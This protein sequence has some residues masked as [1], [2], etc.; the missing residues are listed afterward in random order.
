MKKLRCVFMGT[1]DF[2]VPC[3]AALQAA[4]DVAAV[5]T[6][7][8]RPKGRGRKLSAPPVKEFAVNAGIEVFQPEKIKT[9]E[10]EA[11]IQALKPDV[12]VVV[13]FG[14]ILSGAILETPPLGCINVHASLLPAY[15]GA[16]PI[17]WS[18][19]RGET[20]TGVTTM[21]MDR[22]LDT[23][24]MILRREIDIAKEITTGQLHDALMHMGAEVL[25]DTL[26][27]LAEGKA[28]RQAQ[29]DRLSSYAPL[30]TK[31]IE[32]IDWSKDAKSVH[33]LIRGLNPWPGAHCRRGEKIIKVW[34]GRQAG[35]GGVLRRSPGEVVS[36]TEEGFCVETGDGIVEL[37]EVQ[38]ASKRR[39]SAREYA[40]G[41]GIQLGDRLE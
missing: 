27:L 26:R 25:M 5:V 14:Q 30:L 2:A 41:Y 17:H 24:D 22:G 4:H 38:P 23:G 32:R 20:K 37:L 29:D 36:L 13:A 35:S 34:R 15:R 16:A 19:I 10:F 7:P 11:R 40:A 9:P 8:D 3:L 1:P 18:I 28:P 6:Q 12:I 39:M 31:E 21:F 33:N